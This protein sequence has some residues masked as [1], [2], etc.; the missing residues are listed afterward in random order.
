ME[1]PVFRIKTQFFYIIHAIA[2]QVA[3]K[4]SRRSKRRGCLEIKWTLDGLATRSCQDFSLVQKV[5]ELNNSPPTNAM[6]RANF[7]NGDIFV[8]CPD[9]SQFL[10]RAIFGVWINV[11]IAVVAFCVLSIFRSQV[12]R[13]LLSDDPHMQVVSLWRVSPAVTALEVFELRGVLIRSLL[14]GHIFYA[15]ASVFCVISAIISAASTT[16]SNHVIVTNSV[17]RQSVATGR[18]VTNDHTVLSGAV[19]NVTSRVNILN[20]ANSP[21][22]ELFDFVPN[23]DVTWVYEVSQWN[24]TWHGECGYAKHLAVDLVVYPSKNAT[25]QTEVPLLGNYIPH[26]ATLDPAK[27]GTDYTGFYTGAAANGTGKWADLIV[28]YAFGSAPDISINY[29]APTV[30]ISLVNFLAHNVARDPNTTFLQTSLRSDIHVV[31]C[32]FGN[33]APGIRYQ[34]YAGGGHYLNAAGN[35]ANVGVL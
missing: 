31:D 23:E 29:S 24:N 1:R 20:R 12:K 5:A 8:D 28:T 3:L 18:L 13:Q 30:N 11:C 32:M 9:I 33:A 21:L 6:V 22:N 25:Y 4:I 16:I 17:M 34:A 26:W 14:G 7:A 2:V 15:L 10:L 27:Q 19:V 35:V